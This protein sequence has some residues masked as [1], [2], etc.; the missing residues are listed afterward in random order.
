MKQT[1]KLSIFQAHLEKLKVTHR[2]MA[3]RNIL[4][5]EGKI[6]KISDFGLSRMGTYVKRTSGRIPLR[7]F[8]QI[9]FR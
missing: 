4:V 7:F 9:S 6:L 5:G 1:K 3:A 8:C 2:D